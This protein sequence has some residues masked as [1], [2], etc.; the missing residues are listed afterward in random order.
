MVTRKKKKVKKN[1]KTRK[2]L[3][4]IKKKIGRAHV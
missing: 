1:N 2:R 4:P 3:S